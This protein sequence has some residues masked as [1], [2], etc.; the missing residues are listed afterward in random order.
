[1]NKDEALKKL[2][3]YTKKGCHM[4]IP[5]TQR[6]DDL[7]DQFSIIIDTVLLSGHPKDRDVYPHE[8]GTYDYQ[9]NNWK[10][11][12]TVDSQKVRISKHGL[13]K[14]AI[15]SGIIWSPTLCR[16]IRDPKVAD[17]IAYEAVGGVRKPDGTPY[18]I[19]K[20]YAMDIQVEREKLEFQYSKK[21]KE[22][23]EYLVE[24][25]LLQ[26]KGNLSELCESGARNRVTRE[27]LC[28]NNFYTVEELKKEFVMARIVPKLDLNDPYTKR[29]LVDLQLAA[30]TGIYG[31][32]EPPQKMIECEAPIDIK[33][34]EESAKEEPLNGTPD[35][36]ESTVIDFQNSDELGQSKCL[37]DIS[38]KKGYDL[39]GFLTRS[40]RPDLASV[41]RD[42]KI[43]LFKHLLSLP[44]KG[45]K[46]P[47]DDVPYDDVPF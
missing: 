16:Q 26:K 4:L 38:L 32:A 31:S 24:R 39:A 8:N 10:E 36:I 3:E 1:M 22:D 45:D 42:R 41:P 29:R 18:F 6:I 44:D 30:M 5:T 21:K 34:V 20:L 9:T 7:S 47:Y 2:Q 35:P 40:N 14:L 25:D 12:K 23:R 13:D 27:I 17:R 28:L 46:K 19:P 33:I 11:P 15:L 37:T 43:E